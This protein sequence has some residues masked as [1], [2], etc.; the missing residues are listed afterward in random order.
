LDQVSFLEQ[1]NIKFS[2]TAAQV[3]VTS[4][5]FVETWLQ[6]NHVFAIGVGMS[7]IHLLFG[8]ELSGGDAR[9]RQKHVVA[10]RQNDEGGFGGRGRNI[11]AV[12]CP[13]QG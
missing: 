8:N 1:P 12:A 7:I 10:S 13:S 9:I 4:L 11:G 5:P 2:I 6:V 3:K